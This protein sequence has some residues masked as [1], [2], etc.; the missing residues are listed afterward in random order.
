LKI[1]NQVLYGSCYDEEQLSVLIKILVCVTGAVG[2]GATH[3]FT[4]GTPVITNDN[5]LILMVLKLK[6]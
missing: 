2:L 5:I 1:S 3:S 4:Y 6:L